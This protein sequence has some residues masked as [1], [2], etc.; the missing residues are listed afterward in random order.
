MDQLENTAAFISGFLITVCNNW[1]SQIMNSHLNTVCKTWERILWGKFTKN[2]NN[3]TS[4]Y[5]FSFNCY[6]FNLIF[7]KINSW[8]SHVVSNCNLAL[9]F[10]FNTTF[11]HLYIFYKISYTAALSFSNVDGHSLVHH[12]PLHHSLK[13]QL[14]QHLDFIVPFFS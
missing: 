9:H 3:I 11:T 6:V 12:Q 5:I 13:Q 10:V 4:V 2:N 8:P 14:I 1:C 7:Y